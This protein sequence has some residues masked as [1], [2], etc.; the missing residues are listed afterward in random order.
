MPAIAALMLGAGFANPTLASGKHWR[1]HGNNFCSQTARTMQQACYFD[2]V[3]DYNEGKANCINVVDDEER[4]ECFAELQQEIAGERHSCREQKRARLEVC[5]A[6]G[7]QR[8]ADPL[9][10]PMITFVDPDEIGTTRDPNPYVDLTPGHTYVL[11][12]GEDGEFEETV[13]IHVTD[14]IR[15]AE[16]ADGEAVLCRVVVD[17]AMVFEEEDGEA[18]W[19]SEEVTDDY[20]AQDDAGNVYYC[21]EISRNYEDGYLVNLDGSFF[22]GEEHAKAGILMRAAPAAG[23]VDRQEYAIGE[24]EDVVEYLSL[25]AV[26]SDDEGGNNTNDPSFACQGGAVGD[27][28]M[29][30]DSAALEPESTE[31]KYYR[32]GVG[33]V[34]AVALEDGE[35]DGEREELLCVGDSLDV[36][37]DCDLAQVEELK[38][39][40]CETAPQAFCPEDDD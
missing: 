10:D 37:D 27:C 32:A 2:L 38:E 28:L 39:K 21:G 23:Q 16:G 6:I 40:L 12:V 22:S 9:K 4:A 35:I 29:T 1:G 14:E 11:G 3:D 15:E 31:Y 24:A 5:D 26:P 13:V 17:A 34:L 18:E 7:E 20:F 8:Y 33:F 19:L 25:S 30:L 36:L